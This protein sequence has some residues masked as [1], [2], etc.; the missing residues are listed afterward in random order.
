MLAVELS[1]N[2]HHRFS[3]KRVR[4]AKTILLESSFPDVT[5]ERLLEYYSKPKLSPEAIIQRHEFEWTRP[6]V[7]ELVGLGKELF[8]WDRNQ[9]LRPLPPGCLVWN[10]VNRTRL[11]TSTPPPTVSKPTQ[12]KT[13]PTLTDYFKPSKPPAPAPT[14]P[15]NHSQVLAIHAYR[16]HVSTDFSPELRISYLPPPP[17]STP[18]Q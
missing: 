17:N 1:S 16:S 7:E 11:A 8:D 13:A 4:L 10:L 14:Q 5:V 6:N 15:P 18:T 3:E 12:R 9:L 2:C